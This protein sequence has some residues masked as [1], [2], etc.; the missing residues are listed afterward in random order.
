MINIF[1]ALYCEAHP[2]IQY[3]GMKRKQDINR[4][5]FFSND[6][7]SLLVTGT[8][9][10]NAAMGV[11]SLFSFFAPDSGD[12]L[13]NIGICG[14]ENLNIRKGTVVYCNKI[15]DVTTCK[16]FFPDMLFRHPFTEGTVLTSPVPVKGRNV[17]KTQE[18]GIVVTDMEAYG[19]FHAGSAFLQPH[20]MYFLKIVSDYETGE[21][22]S[23]SR[24]SELIS[25]NVGT[26]SDWIMQVHNEL[27]GKKEFAFTE[28]ER[29][30]LEKAAGAMKLTVSMQH[31][32][33]QLMRYYKLQYGD[34]AKEL[35]D[36]LENNLKESCRTKNEG[37]KCF[38]K[39]R[40]RFV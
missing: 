22:I 18:T 8:G 3:F 7:V 15:V 12:I 6:R 30:L 37:K 20:Q 26:V 36:F 24:A 19:I 39:L 25:D 40:K 31:S 28:E 17:E 1:T 16:S 33:N 23:S 2:L 4:F 35:A 10:L 38:E 34:F 21:K 27:S 14:T 32:L 9:S 5:Q 11:A 29:A 13:V